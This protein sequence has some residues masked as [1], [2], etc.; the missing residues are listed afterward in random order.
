MP[1]LIQ[2]KSINEMEQEKKDT[3]AQ[4]KLDKII[5]EKKEM[6]NILKRILKEMNRD[7]QLEDN[8]N[9]NK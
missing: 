7:N 3:S 5:Q 6:N 9:K 2:D 8:P 1:S 4:D